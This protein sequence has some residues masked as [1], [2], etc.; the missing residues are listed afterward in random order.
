MRSIAVV[1]GLTMVFAPGCR[2]LT[3]QFPSEAVTELR[4]QSAVP[5]SVQIVQPKYMSGT[6][7][8]TFELT[9]M[10]D[11]GVRVSTFQLGDSPRPE[12]RLSVKGGSRITMLVPDRGYGSIAEVER[13]V[14]VYGLTVESDEVFVETLTK[15]KKPEPSSETS[16]P[17]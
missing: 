9:I 6:Q 14:R 5:V 15:P 13:H 2:L 3:E 12:I 16:S 7:D 1:A 8:Q 17:N 10:R 11:S 4:N